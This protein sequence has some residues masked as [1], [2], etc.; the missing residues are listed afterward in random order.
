LT[1]LEDRTGRSDLPAVE[2]AIRVL[3]LEDE[4]NDAELVAA[5]LASDP[6]AC[7][8]TRVTNEV[9]FRA[10][11]KGGAFDLILADYALPT[12]D[13]VT[14]LAIA[15][16]E[17]PH[18]PFII[19]SGTLGEELAIEIL[20]TG[21]TDYVLKDRLSRLVPSVK[22]A[23]REAASERERR[24]A[25]TALKDNQ[26]RLD[27][28][29][30]A[31]R[32]G[33]WSWDVEEDAF[34]GDERMSELL[35]A[36]PGRTPSDIHGFLSHVHHED[37]DRVESEILAARERKV[38]FHVE[39]RVATGDA[40][41][42]HLAT[43]GQFLIDPVTE[44][45]RAI[46]VSWD[47]TNVRLEE[48]QRRLLSTVLESATNGVMITD[49]DGRISW[50]N[51][52]F[53]EL[54]GYTLAEVRGENPRMFKSG[55][56]DEDFYRVMWETLSRGVPWHGQ[57]INRRKD[58]TLYTEETVIC[59]VRGAYG[60]TTSFVCM[61]RDITFEVDLTRQLHQ[62]Q[63]LE[64][65]GRL[66]GGVAHDFNNILT[67]ISGNADLAL[68]DLP[69]DDPMTQAFHEIADASRRAASL[70]R[71][72]LAFSRKQILQPRV[73]VLNELVTATEKMLRRLIGEDVKLKTRL[74]PELGSV[75]ADPGQLEQ[76]LMNLA[77]NARDAMP[78]GGEILFETENIDLH[79]TQ[80][81]SGGV[82]MHSGRYVMLT[83]SDTGE[84]MDEETQSR[85]FEPFFTT[86]EKGKGTGLGL[87]T[88][89]GIVKQSG[90]YIWT[91]SELGK[92][93]SFQIYF[94][95]VENT[96]E[97]VEKDV[98]LAFT[99][100]GETILVVED[101]EVVLKLARSIL[102]RTG[103]KV[104]TARN[105]VEALR[106]LEEHREPLHLLL[107]D[108]VMPGMSGRALADASQSLRQDLRVLF[109]SGY[110]DDAIVHHG[111][112][113]AGAH[114][115]EKPYSR[116]TLLAAVRNVLDGN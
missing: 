106:I 56:H 65:V 111:V 110:T 32:M 91:K 108:V 6:I 57:M 84:G 53:T 40:T 71:Q 73:L 7:D 45:D 39:Y 76:I 34:R 21:A 95:Q 85:I 79:E 96:P 9:E 47:I 41:G 86:K 26:K 19:L 101:E 14:A 51:S 105:G 109:T 11:L 72:L 36:D 94:P 49:A 59:P 78:R 28:A 104:L 112:L 61:K 115:L 64:A 46:G 87:A 25:E 66:A 88:V 80:T 31:S 69:P 62:A 98:P 23:L 116:K 48:Q 82:R 92:G 24:E 75:L 1:L 43:R 50:V 67:V 93:T 27:F 63:R 10:A 4:D 55:K 89:Y 68:A 54:T 100:G 77:V 107:T 103:Y 74:Q 114:L 52:A 37:R 90:G 113:Q 97:R 29:L 8:I 16:K 20:K 13:G 99:R 33:V 35:G 2:G 15:R 42:R 22:R 102:E 58:G 30:R 44:R 18:V 5:A 17:V 12:F 3:H 60:E 81:G 70:T 38:E 83:V